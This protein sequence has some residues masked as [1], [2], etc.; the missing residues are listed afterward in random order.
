[1]REQRNLMNNMHK[2]KSY[3]ELNQDFESF[4]NGV[5][6]LRQH[7]K[8]EV[9]EIEVEVPS[10]PKAKKDTK[11][12][13]SQVFKAE[14][15]NLKSK[16]QQDMIDEQ[17]QY[18]K[19]ID[20]MNDAHNRFKQRHQSHDTEQPELKEGQVFPARDQHQTYDTPI[21]QIPIKS[22]KSANFEDIKEESKESTIK[23]ESD[24]SE[25]E[26]P[27]KV[28]WN[29]IMGKSDNQNKSIK[30]KS[31]RKSKKLK[32]LKLKVDDGAN[33]PASAYLDQPLKRPE[34]QNTFEEKVESVLHGKINQ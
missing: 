7:L 2:P 33:P 34:Q 30:S 12:S 19:E 1:L 4:H 16:I 27:Q 23:Q 17:E 15:D 6:K 31:A 25:C 13:T 28:T 5:E 24:E 20:T 21:E 10:L 29:D 8:Q 22:M 11:E 14:I 26:S 9:E 18:N 32:V 3:I